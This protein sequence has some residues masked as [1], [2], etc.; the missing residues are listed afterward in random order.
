MRLIDTE[1]QLPSVAAE[2][3]G[4]RHLYLDTEFD[5]SK[6]GKKLSLV[7]V[8]KDG[9]EQANIYLIDA[10]KIR[11]LSPLREPFANAAAE[12]VLHAGLQDIE[13]LVERLN[14]DTPRKVFDTQIAWALLGPEA[15]VSLSYLKFK[16]LGIRAG[17]PHQADDWLRRPL[18]ESQLRYAAS[19]IEH[20]PEI[21]AALAE[22]AEAR[23]RMPAIHQASLEIAQP[24]APQNSELSLDS[25]RNAWQL[26]P[27]TQAAL[28]FLIQWYNGRPA[29]ERQRA[30]DN[31][32]LMAIASRVP[33]TALD[34]ARIK[35]VHRG[36][37]N[38]HGE[39]FVNLL[40]SA[41]EN[42]KSE[43]F[44]PIDPPPYATFE[45]YRLE[46]WLALAR[47]E[48]CTE[49]SVAPDLAFPSRI[50]KRVRD[51]LM[52]THDFARALEHLGDWRSELLTPALLAF[53][54]R[55]PPPPPDAP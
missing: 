10:L 19:D 18:P 45:E 15:S 17:K 4:A 30:P 21:R 40:A 9:G 50:L 20:L 35:G 24:N 43:D 55:M 49:L 12:W 25:F 22:R 48:V 29:A 47:A 3:A 13:L 38:R 16:I 6:A 31:K 46:A 36:W 37:V 28:R 11:D 1:T 2:L 34:L 23:Q 32:T 7:Q 42:A 14:I 51:D 41:A 8:S 5:S 26:N 54:K 33:R 53:E 39:R 52:H 27:K 44:V